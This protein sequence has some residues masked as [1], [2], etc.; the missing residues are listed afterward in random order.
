M[1]CAA[2]YVQQCEP[3]PRMDWHR[4]FI[5]GFPMIL[6]FSCQYHPKSDANRVLF[7]FYLMGATLFV[8]IINSVALSFITTPIFQ[9]QIETIQEIVS[10]E[11]N[12]VGN[13]FVLMQ[14]LQ[15]PE[16]NILLFSVLECNLKKN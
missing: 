16:V 11:F 5:N 13:K 15:K 10:N 4:I 1:L 12:F 2:Y 3:P 9:P 14:L 7:A 6:G 8:I